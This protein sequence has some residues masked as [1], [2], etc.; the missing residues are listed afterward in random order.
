MLNFDFS[1]KA[2][3]LALHHILC[4]ISQEKCYSYYILL[5][6]FLTA[7]TFRDIG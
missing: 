6:K 1:Q 3:G 4:M 2:L 5:T 7:F